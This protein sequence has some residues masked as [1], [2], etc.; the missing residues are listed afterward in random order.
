MIYSVDKCI[1]PAHMITK[2][3]KTTIADKSVLIFRGYRIQKTENQP[4]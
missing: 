4:H 2:K 3:S 1:C